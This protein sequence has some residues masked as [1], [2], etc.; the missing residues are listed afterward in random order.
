MYSQYKNHM[1]GT[2]VAQEG[3]A[4]RRWLPMVTNPLAKTVPTRATNDPAAYVQRWDV[5]DDIRVDW[6]LRC[7]I[8]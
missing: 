1:V 7:M 8:V 6:I 4:K 2:R 5:M 3:V